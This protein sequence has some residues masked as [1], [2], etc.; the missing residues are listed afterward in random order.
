MKVIAISTGLSF[1][2]IAR[3]STK[4][5]SCNPN[6][7]GQLVHEVACTRVRAERRWKD[8]DVQKSGG[9]RE[10]AAIVG[11]PARRQSWTAAPP[12]ACALCVLALASL[13]SSRPALSAPWCDTCALAWPC[14]AG[15]AAVDGA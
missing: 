14:E 8:E 5:T 12:A 1:L 15:P 7:V 11:A 9:A 10:G 4:I 3:C 2:F 13:A 6:Q